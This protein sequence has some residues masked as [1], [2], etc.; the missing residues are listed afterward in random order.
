MDII[1]CKIT[2]FMDIILQTDVLFFHLDT[3]FPVPHTENRRDAIHYVSI[4]KRPYKM[5]EKTNLRE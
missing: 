2:H 1:F 3:C 5:G 4:P